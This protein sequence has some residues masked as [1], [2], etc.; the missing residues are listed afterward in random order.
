MASHEQHSMQTCNSLMTTRIG[1]FVILNI[2]FLEFFH[3][4][5]IDCAMAILSNEIEG[6]IMSSRGV[7][8]L[9]FEMSISGLL[10]CFAREFQP[11]Q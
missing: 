7:I 2:I 3:D 6:R 4:P 1:S 5:G 9:L 8:F 11:E 10:S